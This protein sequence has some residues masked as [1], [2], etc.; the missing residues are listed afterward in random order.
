MPGVGKKTATRLLV[1]LKSKLNLPE[2]D[3]TEPVYATAQPNSRTDVREALA[4]LG[5][6][7]RPIPCGGPDRVTQQREQWTDGANAL[8]IAPGLITLYDR[9][10]GTAEQLDRDGFRIVEAEN[11]LLGRDEIDPDRPGRVCV[12]L[13]SH[14]ISRARGGP[15]CLSHPLVRDDLD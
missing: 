11:L 9:N 4:G 2:I 12:L 10:I 13:P 14:E 15:H 3:L 8:A 6:D 5:M 7:L 1:D